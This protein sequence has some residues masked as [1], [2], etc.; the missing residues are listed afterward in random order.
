MQGR[1]GTGLGFLVLFFLA[2]LSMFIL[3][4][5]VL[6]PLVWIWSMIDAYNYGY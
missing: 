1:I 4:G 5:F 3:I 2:F 6:A